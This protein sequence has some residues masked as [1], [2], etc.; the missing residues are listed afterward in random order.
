M[1]EKTNETAKEVPKQDERP[2]SMLEESRKLRDENTAL[3][4]KL[5]AEN[6]RAEKI[7]SESML[8]GTTEGRPKEAPKVEPTPQQ[9]AQAAIEGKVGTPKVE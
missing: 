2:L 7:M 3:L 8:G 6:E 9:Y 4:E 5:R 1:E